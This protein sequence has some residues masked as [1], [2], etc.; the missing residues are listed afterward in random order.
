M[1]VLL[2]LLYNGGRSKEVLLAVLRDTRSAEAVLRKSIAEGAIGTRR[3]TSTR[4]RRTSEAV[5]ELLRR[6]VA[7]ALRTTLRG[8]N[9]ALVLLSTL[10]ARSIA[11]VL[12]K[13]RG[14]SITL[15]LLSKLGR[16]KVLVRLGT[17]R[18]D[19]VLALLRTL[20]DWQRDLRAV[21]EVLTTT[22]AIHAIGA[23]LVRRGQVR[24]VSRHCA[25]VASTVLTLGGIKGSLLRI[26]EA[27]SRET[28][29]ALPG[30]DLVLDLA[31]KG[32]IA[33]AWE[34]GTNGVNQLPLH[35]QG[36]VIKSG[37]NNV[38]AELVANEVIHLARHQ[39]RVHDHI[40]VVV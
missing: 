1:P 21:G 12:N 27:T 13:L 36:S 28:A 25:V 22:F 15:V 32:S 11:L 35:G 14:R 39:Q 9:I 26:C 7:L 4:V 16:D 40:L 19:K 6:S 33:D 37:L 34:D 31:T 17:F 2:V 38:V 30:V 18:R 3:T 23:I 29:T 20:G 24:V 10:R 5:G 8:M